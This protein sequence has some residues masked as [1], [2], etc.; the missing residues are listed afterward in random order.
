MIR[1]FWGGAATGGGPGMGRLLVGAGPIPRLM[2]FGKTA[3]C[4]TGPPEPGHP[5]SARLPRVMAKVAILGCGYTGRALIPP[6]GAAGHE[7]VATTTQSAHAPQIEALGAEVRVARLE[8]PAALRAALAGATRVI[9]LAPPDREAAPAAQVEALA[10]VLPGGLQAYV[11]GSTTGAFGRP[12]G[13]EAWIDET[14]PPRNVTGWGKARLEYEHALAAHGVPLRV[15]RIAGIYG[16]GRT[17][18]DSLQSGMLLFEGG[19]PTSRIHVR[20]LARLLAAAVEDHAPPL[21]LACD[22]RPAPTLEVARYTAE[23]CGIALPDVLS[24]EEARARLSG[25]ALE[26]RLGGRR[27]RSVVREA[28]IGALEFPSY[29]EGV[30]ASLQEEGVC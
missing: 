28:L 17:L 30:K 1:F 23:L 2:T 5:L 4:Y 12:A 8:D 25:P 7:V 27:C 15:V 6:L 24:L 26:M 11:Y 9:H 18:K 21:I 19:P 10:R 3:P 29:V 22:E 16:P 13:P 14:T 20:D